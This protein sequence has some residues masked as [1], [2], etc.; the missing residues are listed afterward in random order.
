MIF[1]LN[2]FEKEIKVVLANGSEISCVARYELD[3][4]LVDL[5][6]FLKIFAL[7]IRISQGL[8]KLITQSKGDWDANID[9]NFHSIDGLSAKLAVWHSLVSD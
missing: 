2:E 5:V 6:D 3:H 4:K 9:I 1:S 7:L 8:D